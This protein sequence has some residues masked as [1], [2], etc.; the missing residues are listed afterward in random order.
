MRPWLSLNYDFKLN[1]VIL[2]RWPPYALPKMV[3]AADVFTGGP[4]H[5]HKLQLK[6]QHEIGAEDVIPGARQKQGLGALPAE[7]T[8]TMN[9][10]GDFA[11]NIFRKNLSPLPGS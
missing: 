8:K 6:S 7:D 11:G 4:A 5:S 10:E 9:L 3:C 2:I 1:M